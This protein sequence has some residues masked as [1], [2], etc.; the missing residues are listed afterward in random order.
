M[1]GRL[2]ALTNEYKIL[3]GMLSY[4]TLWPVGNILEQTLVEDRRFGTYDWRKCIR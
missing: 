2:K 3:R 4:G 1:F